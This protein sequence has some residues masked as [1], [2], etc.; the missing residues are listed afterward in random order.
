[1]II[2]IIIQARSSS[3][4]F[5]GKIL[6]TFNKK[7]LI[8]NI[9]DNLKKLKKINKIIVATTNNNSDNFLCNLLKKKNIFF[10]RGPENNV[11]KRFRQCCIENK[12]DYLIRISADSPF[13]SPNLIQKMIDFL[14]KNSKKN[15]D[16]I[17]SNF[18][19]KISPGQSIEI[20]SSKIFLK[21]EKQI[22]TQNDKEH[23]FPKFYEN[24][25]NFNSFSVMF[26][27]ELFENHNSCIDYPLDLLKKRKFISNS[28]FKKKLNR[29]LIEKI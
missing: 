8:F 4:R 9:L 29:I 14:L 5:K 28:V 13:I 25:K 10:I 3:K 18:P 21:Y 16:I 20:I 7:R 24:I 22:K 26:K 27:D 15:I 19:K 11:Y 6:K 17:T 2:N 1:M 23:V 12:C